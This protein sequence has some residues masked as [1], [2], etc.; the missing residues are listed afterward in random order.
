ME[1]GNL[2]CFGWI[3]KHVENKIV[4]RIRQGNNSQHTAMKEEASMVDKI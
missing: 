4:C 1:I 2:K 3:L